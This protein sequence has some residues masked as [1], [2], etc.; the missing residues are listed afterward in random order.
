MKE[1]KDKLSKE[2]FELREKQ[3]VMVEKICACLK[4]NNANKN[5]SLDELNAL[6]KEIETL[7]QLPNELLTDT[8]PNTNINPMDII[9]NKSNP[10]NCCIS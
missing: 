9:L 3:A 8:C 1:N 4:K 10:E 2:E 6:T 7:G 5:Q